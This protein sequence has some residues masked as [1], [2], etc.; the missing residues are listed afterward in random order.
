MADRVCNQDCRPCKR[1]KHHPA[2]THHFGQPTAEFLITK[3]G[4]SENLGPRHERCECTP[5][6]DSLCTPQSDSSAPRNQSEI[7]LPMH[8]CVFASTREEAPLRPAML[9]SRARARTAVLWSAFW[10]KMLKCLDMTQRNESLES[11]LFFSIGD[12]RHI[13]AARRKSSQSR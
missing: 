5:Q 2:E 11:I 8:K 12:E 4:T 9:R 13:A 1:Q 6:S 10:Q 7:S 3:G